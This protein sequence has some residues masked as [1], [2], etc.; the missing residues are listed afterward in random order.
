[1]YNLEQATVGNDILQRAKSRGTRQ[2]STEWQIQ[3]RIEG[4]ES[5]S[6]YH[7]ANTLPVA[8]EEPSLR[9]SLRIRLGKSAK[10]RK[11]DKTANILMSCARA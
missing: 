2:P 1:M 4:T 11:R 10:K 7:S 6:L 8:V 5:L 9:E 3:S